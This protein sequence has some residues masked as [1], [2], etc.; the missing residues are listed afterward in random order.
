MTRTK[1]GA[2]EMAQWFR[3]RDALPEN[4]GSISSAQMVCN[5]SS[6]RSNIQSLLLLT[7]M[8]TRHIPAIQANTLKIKINLKN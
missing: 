8:G 4:L 6:R 5:S 1:V 3:A 7:P 2:G